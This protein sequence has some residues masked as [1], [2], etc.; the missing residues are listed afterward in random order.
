MSLR[1]DSREFTDRLANDLLPFV[2][3][4]AFFPRICRKAEKK[5]RTSKEKNYITKNRRENRF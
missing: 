2:R 4:N 5:E 3:P 1:S